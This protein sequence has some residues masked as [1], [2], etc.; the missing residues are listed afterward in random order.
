[1][2]YYIFLTFLFFH[3]RILTRK[4]RLFMDYDVEMLKLYF[5]EKNYSEEKINELLDS[6]PF[7]KKYMIVYA[8]DNRSNNECE[9]RNIQLFAKKHNLAIVSPGF[10]HKWADKN[11]NCDPIEL[12]SW[13]KYAEYVVTDTFHGC[14][15]SI[16]T[17]REMA[18]KLRDNANKLFNLMTEYEITD[19][20]LDDNWNVESVFRE[21]VDWIKTNEQIVKRRSASIDYLKRMISI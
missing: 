7:D 9:Y 19:R 17:E 16:I 5:K 14:V 11:I 2:C 13:F 15:M 20:C 10:Y 1:M 4:E 6:N 3:D 8:Y 12:L 21:K 18:V